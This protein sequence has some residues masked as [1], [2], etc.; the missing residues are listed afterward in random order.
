MDNP[1]L[2][3]VMPGVID[4]IPLIVILFL[5]P[6]WLL[7][8]L[9]KYSGVS[10]FKKALLVPV[11]IVAPLIVGLA[12]PLVIKYSGLVGTTGPG[13]SAPYLH[14]ATGLFGEFSEYVWTTLTAIAVFV[15]HKIAKP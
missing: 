8:I 6:I 5:L 15:V 4:A 10:R 1:N 14:Y 13:G 11:C 2:E 12:W 3:F 7:V 9:F